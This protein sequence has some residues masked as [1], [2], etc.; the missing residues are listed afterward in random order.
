MTDKITQT[1]IQTKTEDI[2]GKQVE[3]FKSDIK[4]RDFFNFYANKTFKEKIKTYS[5][6]DKTS[7]YCM[8][9]LEYSKILKELN[10][11]VVKLMLYEA[12]DFKMPSNLGNLSIKKKK[13]EPYI[14]ETGKFINPL[15]VNRKATKELWDR[16]P[17][18]KELNKRVYHHN[19]HSDGYIAKGFY[20]KVNAKYKGKGK[21]FIRLTR[22]I[23]QEINKI[24]MDKFSTFDFFIIE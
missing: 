12:F 20:S 10:S 18:A 24:M 17:E 6:I 19:E 14:D 3:V 23:K 13:V 2:V 7:P 1:E 21:Y 16:D 11:E 8:S 4:T 9:L 15:P 5:R 22:S